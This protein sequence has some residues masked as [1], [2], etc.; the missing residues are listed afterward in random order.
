MPHQG[1]G[2][3]LHLH[4]LRG[5]VSTRALIRFHLDFRLR[6]IQICRDKFIDTTDGP[7]C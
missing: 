6:T 1:R 3:R 7:I 2:K 4:Q 5:E